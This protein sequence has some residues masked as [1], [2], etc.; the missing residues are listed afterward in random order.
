MTTVK[1]KCSKTYDVI[2][3]KDILNK[4]GEFILNVKKPCKVMIVSDDNVSEL[5]AKVVLESLE[6]NGFEVFLFVFPNGEHS[7]NLDTYTKCIEYLANEHF[8]RT[9]LVVALGGGIVGDIAGFVAA[10]F[11]RGISVIQI[12]TTF[13]AAV[14]SSVGG[15][16][17]VNLSSGKNLVGA[18]W[19]PSQV[20]CD[21]ETFKTLNHSTFSDGI[22]ET[23]KYGVILDCELFDLMKNGNLNENL[24]DIVAKCVSLKSFVV[25]QDEHDNGMRQLLNFGH[26]IGHAIEK[27]SDYEISHGHAVSIGMAIVS[28]ASEKSGFCDMQCAQEIINLL[29]KFN[30][31]V[32]TTYNAE[33]LTK[34]ALSDK[35]R[36]SDELTI[37]VPEKIGKCYLKKINVSQLENF[38][39]LGL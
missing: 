13:L 15:K 36:K 21:I 16:A 9:D 12:P 29:V 5:Y 30:L 19:Q 4:C 24:E 38:I 2:I 28:K 10:T 14:D 8:T 18:F 3:G 31:P 7:K 25:E 17:G 35:K 1:V 39:R 26:T 37:V 33:Q 6:N 20:I 22:S 27:C 23:V 11:L 34:V 32:T